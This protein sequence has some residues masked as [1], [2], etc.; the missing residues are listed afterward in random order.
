MMKMHT[1][2]ADRPLRMLDVPFGK[3]MGHFSFKVCHLERG[4]AVVMEDVPS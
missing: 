3:R 2:G 4:R 1:L